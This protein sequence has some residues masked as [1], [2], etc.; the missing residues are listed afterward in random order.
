[1]SWI[2]GILKRAHLLPAFSEDDVLNASTE[3]ALREHTQLVDRV[4]EVTQKRVRGN[5]A[6]RKSI[7]SAKHRT[8]SF[9]DFEA[10]VSRGGER[11]K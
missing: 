6:L 3:D 11:K 8:N 2:T 7:M 1:M 4:R 10:F 5:D 9:A